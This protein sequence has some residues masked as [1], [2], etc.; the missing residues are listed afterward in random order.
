MSVEPV[1][2][3]HLLIPPAF[4]SFVDRQEAALRYR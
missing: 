1:C 3:G 2:T 4:A